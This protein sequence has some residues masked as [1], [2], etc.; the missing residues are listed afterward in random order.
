MRFMEKV[1]VISA[2]SAGTAFGEK[3]ASETAAVR[4]PFAVSHQLQ[5]YNGASPNGS[6]ATY[7]AAQLQLPK[8]FMRGYLKGS[9]SKP[10]ALLQIEGGTT[11]LVRAGDTVSLYEVGN[12]MVV[13]IKSISRQHLVV[14]AGS[15][16]EMI[17]IR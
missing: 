15:L 3:A 12:Q 4:D 13:Q 6:T 16:G 1:I 5:S 17:I 8:M 2:L 14:E 9:G 10:A 7:S 11:Q